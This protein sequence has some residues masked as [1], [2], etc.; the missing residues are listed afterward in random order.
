MKKQ[1][2]S[3][4]FFLLPFFS[5][6]SEEIQTEQFVNIDE[7]ILTKIMHSRHSGYE[8]DSARTIKPEVVAHLTKFAR[9][10][11]SSYNEQ[12]WRFIFADRKE[13]PEAYAKVLGSLVEFN[14]NWAKNAPLL[15]VV[16]ARSAFTKSDKIN[17]V[18][19]YDTGAASMSL[20]LGATSMGLMAHQMAGF[21]ADQIQRKF[22]IPE[23]FI[24]LAVIAVGYESEDAPPNLKT[25]NEVSQN[26]FIGTWEKEL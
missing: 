22:K 15:I 10:A 3:A 6:L 18:A 16:A 8:F 20:V 1:I 11:P 12:P 23:G 14:Q 9:L 13:N 21:D 2:S 25:R 5:L 17:S 26:F 4:L 7:A 24:P 19:S